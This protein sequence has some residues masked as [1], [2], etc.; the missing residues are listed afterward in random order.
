MSQFDHL[1]LLSAFRSSNSVESQ[2]ATLRAIKNDLTGHELRKIE[3]IRGGLIPALSRV[4]QR[5]QTESADSNLGEETV[6]IQATNIL[7]SL[8]YG[9]YPGTHRPL[10]N[11]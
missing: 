2:T 11:Y 3:Y 4:L 1:R 9:E 10:G 5:A 7:G 6:W 8:A